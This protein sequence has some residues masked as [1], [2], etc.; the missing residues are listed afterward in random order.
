MATTVAPMQLTSRTMPPMPVAAPS[1]GRI[2]LGWLWLSWEMTTHHWSS[3]AT[4]PESSTGPMTT[5]GPSV[6]RNSFS[7]ARE[8]L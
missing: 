5:L 4:I 8:L 1:L 2:W 7:V 3:M 6:G